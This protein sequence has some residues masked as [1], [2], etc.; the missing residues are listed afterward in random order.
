M[1]LCSPTQTVALRYNHTNEELSW[2][3]DIMKIYG[4]KPVDPK[5]YHSVRG[6]IAD[7]FNAGRVSGIR[8]ERISK[9]YHQL[10]TGGYENE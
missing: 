8:N 2:A 10:K 4:C 9:K 3:Q 1:I 5:S 7:V 6:M